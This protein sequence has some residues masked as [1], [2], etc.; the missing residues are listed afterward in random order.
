MKKKQSG[1]AMFI[2]LLT[3]I[4][5]SANDNEGGQKTIKPIV[6]LS[7]D[8]SRV[9]ERSYHRICTMDKWA[10]IWQKHTGQDKVIYKNTDDEYDQFYDP[11][12]LPMVDFEHYMVIAIFEGTSG[13]NAGMN[14][15]SI[16][17]KDDE[18]IL[19][20]T[21]KPYGTAGPKGGGKT[22]NAFGFFVIPRAKKPLVLEERVFK[23]AQKKPMNAPKPKKKFDSIEELLRK[24]GK[25]K[26]YTPTWKRR[27][28]F[29][30][31][32]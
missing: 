7:G 28:K 20:F 25:A 4:S 8:D 13:N 2:C 5:L 10:K 19:R 17:E 24:G 32:D 29:D 26:M 9:T 22:V 23:S 11:L 12:D 3:C 16:S 18:I 30:A 31:I 1:L 27:I 15:D 14:V 21:D 6:T